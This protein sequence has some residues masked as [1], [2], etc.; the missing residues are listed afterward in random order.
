MNPCGQITV[1]NREARRLLGL[2]D[3]SDVIG[4]AA[5]DILPEP[6]LE[7]LRDSLTSS[8]GVQDLDAVLRLPAGGELPVRYGTAVFSSQGAVL[9]AL[10]VLQDISAIRRLEEQIRR[11][12]RLSSIGTLAA[13]MAHE[14]KNPLVCL[15]TF[16]QLLPKHFEDPD[17]RATFIPLLGKE[18]ERIDVIVS[19]LLDFSHPVKATRVPISL[20]AALDDALHLVSQR[21]KAGGI[22]LDQRY[23]AGDDRVL[24][25]RRLLGQVFVNL[26]LNGI[27]AMNAGGTLTVTTRSD[28]RPWP[29][30]RAGR[31]PTGDW[32]EVSVRDTG[33][34]IAV[35]DR[36]RVFDPFFTTKA[37]GT[38][39]GLAV[40]HSII[41]D[42]QGTIDVESVPGQGACFRVYLPLLPAIDA[43]GEF[44]GVP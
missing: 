36:A 5:A 14:I 6:F 27:E 41:V 34:G 17:F 26:L 25:D 44:E 21:S 12:D 18:V 42:H 1:C 29:A 10:M 2:A 37:N 22:A 38:G 23:M 13:G 33:S 20:H 30:E 32:I 11:G 28:V 39:L 7:A 3:S 43:G 4:R 8:R 9:G 40:S 16:V 35:A 31:S 19:Q 24:G 15:K